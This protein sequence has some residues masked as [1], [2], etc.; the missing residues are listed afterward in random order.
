MMGLA[1]HPRRSAIDL[2]VRQEQRRRLWKANALLRRVCEDPRA[3]QAVCLKHIL[4]AGGASVYGRQHDYARLG[5]IEAFQ[6]HVPIADYHTIEPFIGKIA[7]GSNPRALTHERVMAFSTSS[8][9]TAAPKLI[10]ISKGAIQCELLASSMYL[11]YLARDHPSVLT[12]ETF[13]LFDRAEVGRTAAGLSYGSN[14]GFMFL[15]TPAFV[16]RRF[17]ALPYEIC[18]IQD[19]ATRYYTTLR[20]LL[21]A[22]LTYLICVNPWHAV[23]LAALMDAW[24]VDL[25]RDLHDGGLKRGLLMSSEQYEFF[26][27]LARPDPER[28]HHL[29]DD[30]DRTGRLEPRAYWP[31]LSL[32]SSWKGGPSRFFLPELE[33]WYPGVSVRDT[34]YGSSEFRTGTVLSDEGAMTLL[35]PTNYFYEF[36]PF[37]EAADYR[38][39]RRPLLL[40]D[41]LQM[42][43]KYY[44]VQSGP[45]GLVRYDVGD[46]VEVNGSAGRIP[47][48]EFVQRGDAQTSIAGEHVYEFEVRDAVE[49]AAH[50][51]GCAVPGLFLVYADA[52]AGRY[53]IVFQMDQ[54]LLEHTGDRISAAVDHALCKKSEG[55]D[56]ARR[57]NAISPPTTHFISRDV[58]SKYVE[59]LSVKGLYES[60]V[61]I[62]RLKPDFKQD[63]DAL[64]LVLAGEGNHH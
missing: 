9:T 60:Q 21:H 55:Y 64:N 47:T 38:S 40:L 35:L 16:R 39:G 50:E 34:G 36:I 27:R 1:Q 29:S 52:G 46:I 51:V 15:R 49:L 43:G 59:T 61:K 62:T 19:Y 53:R 14:S 30:A 8:G 3:A 11:S 31:R 10:P 4:R 57:T 20:L 33:A 18:L 56:E 13:Y 25:L 32:I 63:S 41:E 7:D 54:C 2:L 12:G 48:V 58:A 26:S 22:D 44:P 17:A 37:R 23:H 45:H 28:A 24:K 6:A 5:S 42:G